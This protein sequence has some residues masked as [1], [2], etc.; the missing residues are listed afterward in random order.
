MESEQIPQASKTY[1]ICR[2][3]RATQGAMK[4]MRTVFTY[5]VSS[6]LAFIA[7]MPFLWMVSTSLKDQGQIFAWPPVFIPR[8]TVWEN[9]P[10]VLEAMPFVRF[11]FNTTFYTTAVTVGQLTFCSL[12]GYAFAR[13]R[14]PGRD[15]LFSLYLGT[16]MIPATVTIVPSFMLMRWLH[17]VN[18]I[19][20]MTIPGMFGSAFGTFLMRQFFLTIPA[21]LDDAAT[22]DGASKLRIFWQIDLPLVRPALTVLTVFTIMYVWNDFLWPLIMLRDPEVTTLTLGLARFGGPGWQAYTNWPRLMAASTMAVTPLILIF[23]VGQR[24]FIEGIALSGLTG[25]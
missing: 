23:L 19:W 1:T 18:S 2:Q 13:L 21:E 8:P 25:R 5:A 4:S 15:A 16:M 24:Y 6:L 17:W 9:Y 3:E 11:F 10:A 14:F 20:A 22:I 7:L 12:A